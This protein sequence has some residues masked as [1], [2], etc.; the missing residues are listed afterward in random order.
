MFTHTYPE[1]T[2]L[3]PFY[4][5]STSFTLVYP[6]SSSFYRV[7]PHIPRV[8]HWKPNQYKKGD[9]SFFR[10]SFRLARKPNQSGLAKRNATLIAHPQFYTWNISDITSHLLV[11]GWLEPIS[12]VRVFIAQ[13]VRA[14]R[15]NRLG[16]GSNPTEDFAIQNSI[17]CS[18]EDQ[19]NLRLVINL[20]FRCSLRLARKSYQS[21][22]SKSKKRLAKRNVTLIVPSNHRHVG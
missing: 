17:F 10:C 13:L 2:P 19:T 16:L 20:F 9:Q 8:D 15:R 7:Y 5:K 4:P 22:L 12:D 1:L 18:I 21:G 14:P 6:F 3:H 11:K